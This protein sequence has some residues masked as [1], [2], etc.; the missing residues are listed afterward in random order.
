MTCRDKFSVTYFTAMLFKRIQ[1]IVVQK[2]IN[3]EGEGNVFK[4]LVAIVNIPL[5]V[6]QS[7]VRNI[8]Q[9]QQNPGSFWFIG[10]TIHER[11]DSMVK[12][13]RTKAV[14]KMYPN[15]NHSHYKTFVTSCCETDQLQCSN[16]LSP[17][18]RGTYLLIL[19]CEPF[20]WYNLCAISWS[21]A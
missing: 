19:K 20:L 9:G 7:R 1:Y 12:I 14:P 5:K 16:L 2:N 11:S 18:L 3:L 13:G 6:G 21:T 4:G 8:G 17:R 10:S 15:R